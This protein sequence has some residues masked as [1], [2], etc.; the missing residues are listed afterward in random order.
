MREWDYYFITD[1]KLTPSDIFND[2]RFAIEAGCK[3]V[4]YREK[5]KP[6][7]EM[8]KEA[9]LLR[10]LCMGKADFIVNDSIEVC[11]ASDAD[12]VH[13][14]QGD[15]GLSEARRL[16]PKKIIG[17]TVHNLEEAL[18][19]EKGGADYVGASPIFSTRT[20]KDAGDPA[21]PE[22]LRLLR[23]NISIPI[24]AIGGIN[25]D[26]LESVILA[27]ADSAAMISAVLSD[28]KVSEDVKQARSVMLNAKAH[29]LSH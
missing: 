3:V 21:G 28:G 6:R 13:I 23:K 25:F 8:M 26:N 18:E 24:V 11:V 20:K 29:K 16:L 22:L 10:A 19:A 12:G 1:S 17:V 7:E 4:Q 9:K 14:G 5:E 2:A 27:G 15:A